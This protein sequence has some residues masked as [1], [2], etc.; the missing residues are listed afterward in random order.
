MFHFDQLGN[1]R[2]EPRRYFSIVDGIH[3]GEGNGPMAPDLVRA[4]V[5]VAGFNPVAV[6]C[7]CAKL[8]GFDW[9]KIPQLS[10]AFNVSRLPIVKFSYDDIVSTSNCPEFDGRIRDW[11][12]AKM[13]SFRPHFGWKGHVEIDGRL[14]V[15]V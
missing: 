7:A 13:M 6:D 12:A 5:L 4:G 2:L 14:P 15:P 1:L 10:H 11:D 8:M 9:Q 3:A